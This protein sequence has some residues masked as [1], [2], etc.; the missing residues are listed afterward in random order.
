MT[1]EGKVVGILQPGYLP[2]P[3]FFEQMHRSDVFVLYDDVPYDRQG[4]RNR[5]RVKTA[6]GIAWLTVPVL[7]SFDEQP[8]IL[9][10]RIDNRRNWRRKHLETLRQSYGKAPFFEDYIGAFEEA[11]GKE[12]ELLVDLDLHFIDLMK[13]ALGLGGT[14]LRR[15]SEFGVGGSRNERLAAICHFLGG[16]TFYEGAA[17]R[18]YIDEELFRREGI[19]VIFQDYRPRPYRQLHGEFVPFLSA[20]DLLFNEGPGSLRIITA[21]ATGKGE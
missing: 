17:G 6:N 1:E 10:V 9:D 14:T 5:N 3:G 11:Y 8:P 16:G 7:S 18:S 20:V 19:T 12:W 15:S 21:D 2:W 13:N 4:W